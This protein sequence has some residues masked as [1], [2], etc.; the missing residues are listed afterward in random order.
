LVPAGLAALPVAR[1]PPRLVLGQ[2]VGDLPVVRIDVRELLAVSVLHDE[3]AG[4][5]LNSPGWR[6]A[7]HDGPFVL[8]KVNVRRRRFSAFRPRASRR[9]TR[10]L[11][12]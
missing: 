2:R 3:A 5:L 9:A 12:S 11:S 10:L 8:I 4:D 7:A 1:D 6:E